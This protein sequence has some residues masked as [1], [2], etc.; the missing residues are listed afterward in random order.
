MRKSKSKQN[1]EVRLKKL[2]Q[3]ENVTFFTFSVPVI[4]LKDMVPDFLSIQYGFENK[5]SPIL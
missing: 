3:C 2:L 5:I 4:S 1:F